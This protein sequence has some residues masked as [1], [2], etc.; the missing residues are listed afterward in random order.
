V[1][2]APA[3]TRVAWSSEIVGQ[4][5]EAIIVYL[6]AEGT[7]RSLHP[8]HAPALR[9]G[10]HPERQPGDIV[11]EATHRY[12]LR[13]VLVHSTSWRFEGARVILTYVVAVEPPVVPSEYLSDEPVLRADLA[14]GDALGPP[15][16]IDLS[17]VLEHAFRH[18]AWLVR[19][20]DAVRE[21]LPGWTVFLD[22]YEPEPFR[23][24]GAPPGA[25]PT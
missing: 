23:S 3:L 10:W 19:D 4:T 18:L 24:F 2:Q 7:A 6:G 25:P 12:G 9:V 8:I 17:Q 1:D 20:D 13:P 5:L 15:T 16:D 21:A 22:A 11:L 14:R